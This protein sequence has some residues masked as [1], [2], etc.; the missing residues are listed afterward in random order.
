MSL[1]CTN[2]VEM[3][4]IKRPRPNPDNA[5]IHSDEQVRQIAKSVET[6]QLNRTIQVDENDVIL[7]GH[8]LLQ[9]LNF[10]GYEEVPVQVLRHLTEAQKQTY[11]IADNQLALNSSWDEEKLGLTLQKLENDLVNLEVIGFSPQELDRL[12]ADLEPEDLIGDPE[13]VPEA[14]ALTVTIPGDLWTLGRHRVLCGDSLAEGTSGRVLDG[15]MAD[16]VFSDP[17]YNVDYKQKRGGKK[18]ANDN[19]GP[20]FQQFLESAC[21][22]FLAATKGAVYICMSSSELDTLVRA[23]K[24]AGG[25]WS[26]FV[27]WSKDRFTLGR[28][29]YQRQFEV[30][31]YGWKEGGERFW[32][33]AR[34]EGDVWDVPKPKSNRLHPTMKPVALIERA[35]RNSSQRGDLVLDLFGGAGSTLIACEKSG[36]RAA[37]V[38]LEPKYVDVIVR[39]WQNYTH[40]KARL[41]GDGR[42]FEVVSNGRLLEAA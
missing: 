15:Q 31:L 34:D 17:P 8:G 23:F 38:E 25:H 16:M 20:A 32:C 6:H 7:T 21:A 11:V 39:R 10:L 27:I 14:L 29:D 30:I 37:I 40:Q 36:R 22:R 1:P 26:D 2:P 18:I 35:I 33:G 5:R 13:D 3:W 12:L 9:A 24:A 41:D 4:P 19:L 42:S 28:S